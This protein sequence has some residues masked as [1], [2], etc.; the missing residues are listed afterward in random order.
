MVVDRCA[1]GGTRT[2]TGIAHQDLNLA[3]LPFRHTRGEGHCLTTAD[4]P[5]GGSPGTRT[6]NLR[7]KS[8]LL[9]Q[10][11]LATHLNGAV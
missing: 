4:R 7:I 11:E 8:P 6:R 10:I 3:R 5:G 1:G 2:P 9:C